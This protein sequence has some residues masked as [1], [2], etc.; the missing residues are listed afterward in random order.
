LT[1]P[2]C[3]EWVEV[4]PNNGDG[5]D[6]NLMLAHMATDCLWPFRIRCRDCTARLWQEDLLEHQRDHQEFERLLQKAR[7]RSDALVRLNDIRPDALH[8][9]TALELLRK[10][11]S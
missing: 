4:S 2:N 8:L 10:E 6:L 5:D 11:L 9:P 1:C 7:E 3:T